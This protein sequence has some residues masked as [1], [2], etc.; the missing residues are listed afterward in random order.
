ML[1]KWIVE[2]NPQ[3]DLAAAGSLY[4]KL[5]NVIESNR[6]EFFVEQQKLIDYNREQ[7]VL[8][9]TWPG[10]LFLESSD[11]V[12]I[13]IVTSTKTKEVFAKG[14]ENDI[15]LFGEKE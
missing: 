15:E 7:H 6:Q 3:F 4:D 10:Y 11:T 14:E 12:A 1:M 5:A 9:N 8:V 13:K 2:S